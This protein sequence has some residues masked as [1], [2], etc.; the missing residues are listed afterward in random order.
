MAT[1]SEVNTVTLSKSAY[2]SIRST[3]DRA[4]MLLREIMGA[5][6]IGV[7]NDDLSLNDE[8]II[9]TIEILYPDSYRKK[10][11]ALKMTRT[12]NYLNSHK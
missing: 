7:D 11:S 10:V 5:M 6:S 2:D 1:G 4:N 3:N 9:K 8:K 12:K